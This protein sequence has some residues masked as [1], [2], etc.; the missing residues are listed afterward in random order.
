MGIGE[1]KSLYFRGGPNNDTKYSISSL[2]ISI[3]DRDIGC[4][5]PCRN[6]LRERCFR[7]PYTKNNILPFVYALLY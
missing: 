2:K 6:C 5:D 3:L 7:D 1:A 4:Y